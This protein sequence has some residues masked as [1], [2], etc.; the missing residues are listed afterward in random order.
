MDRLCN[1]ADPENCTVVP[2]GTIC[3]RQVG[4]CKDYPT[5]T[6]P[7]HGERLRCNPLADQ[8]LRA[9]WYC[10]VCAIKDQL[11]DDEMSVAL[12]K[13]KKIVLE[14]TTLMESSHGVS[15]LHLNGDVADWDWLMENGWLE[16]Y[17]DAK[18]NIENI[19]G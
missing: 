7:Q 16:E 17:A 2:E 1:C 19:K 13:A 9:N 8:T 12:Y 4:D 14:F 5:L 15:G 11:S 6:C 18:S 3:R 10:P